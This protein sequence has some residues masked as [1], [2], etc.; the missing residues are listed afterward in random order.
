MPMINGDRITFP[1]LT[2]KNVGPNMITL[3]QPSEH[4]CMYKMQLFYLLF[5]L[6]IE[7]FASGA[8]IGSTS[9]C[10]WTVRVSPFST[11]YASLS[12]NSVF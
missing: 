5:F 3:I 10:R 9:S 12:L 1:L 2:S 11:S 7:L 8:K 4:L 6:V